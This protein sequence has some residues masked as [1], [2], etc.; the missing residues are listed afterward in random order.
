MPIFTERELAFLASLRTSWKRLYRDELAQLLK[1]NATDTT[2]DTL[3]IPG[4]WPSTRME[5]RNR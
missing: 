4:P 5:S 1:E 3:L 2:S